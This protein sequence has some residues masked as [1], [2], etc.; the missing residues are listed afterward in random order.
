[1]DTRE[2]LI[3]EAITD[4]ADHVDDAKA[5]LAR[6]RAHR[7]PL[8]QRERLNS[9]GTHLDAAENDLFQ[10]RDPEEQLTLDG[11]A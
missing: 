6:T 3:H 5:A 8:E 1:M 7:L 2:D 4:A 10:A 9:A 11:A